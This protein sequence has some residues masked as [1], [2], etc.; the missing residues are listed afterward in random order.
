MRLIDADPLRED[1][2]ENTVNADV[3]SPN[4]VLYSIDA[5]PTVEATVLPCKIGDVAWG[6]RWHH[7]VLKA[8]R[9]V[10]S[11]MFFCEDMRLCIVIAHICRGEWGKK[12][13]A[14]YEDACAA[15]REGRS[16]G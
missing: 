6:I 15:I 9:G 10:V 1:W 16:N 2:L 3:Y 4:D 12:V 13:F 8:Q 14:T 5:Q 11:N 7:G